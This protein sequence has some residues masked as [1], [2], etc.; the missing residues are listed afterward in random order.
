MYPNLEAEMARK[1]ITRDA[2][3]KKM[4]KTP[5][6]L[7]KK[8]NGVVPLTLPECIRIKDILGLDLD[9]EFLFAKQTTEDS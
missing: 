6:T 8:L 9:I 5:T 2:L 3:A 1:K 7:G 4:G